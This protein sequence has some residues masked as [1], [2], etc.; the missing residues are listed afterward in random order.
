MWRNDPKFSEV[1]QEHNILRSQGGRQLIDGELGTP[2][3]FILD[4]VNSLTFFLRCKYLNSS[5]S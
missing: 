1:R 3:T 4:S 5:L 2:P